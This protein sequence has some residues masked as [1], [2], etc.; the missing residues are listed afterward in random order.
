M[1]RARH[2]SNLDRLELPELSR[3]ADRSGSPVPELILESIASIED[4]RTRH[5]ARELV[6]MPFGSRIA[7]T[8]T[9]RR[10]SAARSFGQSGNYFR[11]GPSDRSK[12]STESLVLAAI[13]GA[14]SVDA[15]GPGDSDD[16]ERIPCEPNESRPGSQAQSTPPSLDRSAPPAGRDRGAAVLVLLLTASL[17]LA[18]SVVWI[19]ASQ[20]DGDPTADAGPSRGAQRQDKCRRTLGTGSG[21]LMT[22]FREA[23]DEAQAGQG[24]PID[25]VDGFDGMT[26]QRVA[27]ESAGSSW[28]ALERPDGRFLAVPWTAWKR[29]R[30]VAEAGMGFDGFGLPS[31]WRGA[32][33]LAELSLDG[34]LTI[35][36]EEA[37]GLYFLV[38]PQVDQ[39]WHDHADVL[40][41]PFSS[42]MTTSRQDFAG[43]Y[44]ELKGTEV[45]WVAVPDASAKQALPPRSQRVDAI[46]EQPSG[47][48]WWVDSADRRWSIRSDRVGECLGG[49]GAVADDAVP[50]YAIAQLELAGVADC[51]LAPA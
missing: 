8:L 16:A 5:A 14:L 11:S 31:S 3:L 17:A 27:G 26:F 47:I 23:L 34:G 12:P 1:L 49:Q 30:I 43:G 41:A 39:L 32:T 22:R 36:S 35:A 48:G 19:V 20:T 45:T 21:F 15:D 51:S 24:C 7:P 50:G 10:I 6:P 42:G 9:D 13:A 4:T 37:H 44:V 25:D 38:H 40:G 33:D 46:V 29:Y 28:V 18:G 2:R